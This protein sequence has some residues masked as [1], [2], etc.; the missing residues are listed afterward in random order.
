MLQPWLRSSD[1]EVEEQTRLRAENLYKTIN[2]AGDLKPGAS[3][4]AYAESVDG[5]QYPALVSQ[6]FGRGRSASW[7]LGDLWRPA[8]HRESTDDDT[9]G[10]R[11]RQITHWLVNDVP[12][13]V[14]VRV[15]QSDDP[16]ES[17]Q[18]IATVRD[19][20]YLPLDNAK[21]TFEITPVGGDAFQM[22]GEMD[23]DRPGVYQSQYWSDGGTA[24]HVSAKA[25]SMDGEVIGESETGWTQSPGASEFR[26]L[27]VDRNRLEQ[28]A[29]KTGGR[30]ITTSELDRFAQ[31]LPNQKV[32]VTESWLYPLWHSPFVMILAM[33]CLCLDWG[34]RRWKGMA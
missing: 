29:A 30:V 7:L 15:E 18:L 11:W 24:F 17:V 33:T 9:T 16:N 13:R 28:I 2:A 6:R 1:T 14:E 4:L 25:M 19:E 26:Q 32:P 23:D 31:A 3:L 10:Q 27:D 12:R 8:M 34:L 20:A 5:Q 22:E 21:V